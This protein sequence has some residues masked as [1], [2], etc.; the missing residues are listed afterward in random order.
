MI[1]PYCHLEKSQKFYHKTTRFVE[2][3]TIN[4]MNRQVFC[5]NIPQRGKCNM[6]N[7]FCFGEILRE[8]REKKGL[9]QVEFGELLGVKGTTISK[10]ETNPNPPDGKTIRKDAA[11]TCLWC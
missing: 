11:T 9:T 2:H 1:P 5:G 8:L 4:S 7:F 3:Y 6:E 10:Y